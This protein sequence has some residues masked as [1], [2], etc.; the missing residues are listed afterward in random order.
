MFSLLKRPRS[1]N[2]S[3]VLGTLSIQILVSKY[4]FHQNELRHLRG[5]EF[6][7][8]HLHFKHLLVPENKEMVKTNGVTGLQK[9]V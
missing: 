7:F 9:S 1:N 3:A 8:W 2:I 6:T 5:R 4:I